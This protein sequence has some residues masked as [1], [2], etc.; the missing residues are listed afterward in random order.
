MA[1]AKSAIPEGL[2]SVT[3]HLV[4]D[5]AAAAIDWYKAG[6]G[7]EELGR[8]VG[9]DGK[10]MHAEIRIGNS[11]LYLNDVMGGG[12]S[13]KVLGGSPIG[14]WIYAPDADALFNRALSAGATVAPG[15]MGQMQDQFWGDRCGT[16]IDPA[17]YQWTIATRTEDLT[18]EEM[19]QRQD[20]FFR[21]FAG[22]GVQH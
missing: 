8:A 3:P 4:F 5:D 7:A 17:G 11:V 12:K 16:L 9:A 19:K 18:P 2:H 10:I 15:P 6:F 20:E 21:Q 22:Q 14:L 13:P 1:K